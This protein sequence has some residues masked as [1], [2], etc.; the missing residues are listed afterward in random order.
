MRNDIGVEG[1]ILEGE[2]EGTRQFSTCAKKN[3]KANDERA[4]VV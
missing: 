4:H 3:F 2:E 1:D